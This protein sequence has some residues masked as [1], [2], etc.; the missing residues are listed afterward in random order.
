MAW[1]PVLLTFSFILFANGIGLVPV[2][3]V[4]GSINRFLLDVPYSDK[5]NTINTILNGGVTATA[6][7][8]VTGA[9]ALL[10]FLNNDRWYNGARI[11]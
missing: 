11:F 8:N 1:A 5:Y 2:F 9:L 7:F 6:N 4:L 10:L 3:D